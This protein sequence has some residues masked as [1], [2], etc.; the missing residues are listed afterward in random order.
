MAVASPDDVVDIELRVVAGALGGVKTDLGDGV[1]ANELNFG[2]SFPYLALPH[3]GSEPRPGS[4]T[5]TSPET[6]R[7]DTGGGG[8]QGN[9]QAG[10][11]QD[12]DDDGLPVL[13]IVAGGL[14]VVVLVAVVA[15][16]V[17]RRRR[18]A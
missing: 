2:R 5:S 3:S 7:G 9:E 16:L 13:G 10:V 18:S 8:S 15:A 4:L 17:V 1:D 14:G 12:D 11:T 6:R